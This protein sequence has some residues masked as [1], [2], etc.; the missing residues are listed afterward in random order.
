MTR[1]PPWLRPCWLS[2]VGSIWR[3]TSD[4]P[5]SL[6]VT[7]SGAGL[8]AFTHPQAAAIVRQVS[9]RWGLGIPTHAG[10]QLFV[11]SALPPSSLARNRPFSLASAPSAS[12]NQ[13]AELAALEP[14]RRF[15]P[16]YRRLLDSAD[17]D[18]AWFCAWLRPLG[19]FCPSAR[20]PWPARGQFCPPPGSSSR[21]L[22]LRWGQTER[23][24]P[25]SF[26]PSVWC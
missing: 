18:T 15:E 14:W 10:I 24:L 12:W 3:R 9:L 8:I 16:R 20:E 2:R 23:R 17:L 1:F 4:Q 5:P 19:I 7:G 25:S 21:P 6:V 26:P 13:E 11:G 22:R